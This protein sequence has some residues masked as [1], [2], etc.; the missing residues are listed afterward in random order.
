M[1]KRIHVNI[2]AGILG[3]LYLVYFFTV[4]RNPLVLAA[5]DRPAGL[6]EIA[7][8]R[9][10]ALAWRLRW[11][12]RLPGVLARAEVPPL[13]FAQATGFAD[14]SADERARHLAARL[15]LT[16]TGEGLSLSHGIRL[17]RAETP[18]RLPLN[19]PRLRLLMV[20]STVPRDE[21]LAALY[22][23]ADGRGIPALVISLDDGQRQALRDPAIDP[24]TMVAVPTGAELTSLLL[25]PQ[26]LDVF[27]RS[28]ASQ[29]SVT[30]ISLYQR[31]G[32]VH[33]S[34]GFF[35]R[36]RELS[37]ILNRDLANYFLIGSRQIGKS[38][39]MKEI[40][41]RGERRPD[42]DCR[43][44]TLTGPDPRGP[45]ARALGMDPA[46]PLDSV[47]D[48]LP[49]DG[50]RRRLILIDEADQF[51]AADAGH[52]YPVLSAFRRLSEEG[53][54]FFILAGFWELHRVIAYDYQSP[55]RN[56][57][58]PLLLGGLDRQAC[59]DLATRPMASLALS[60]ASP[61][62]PALI[63]ERTGGRANLIAIVC[64]EILAELPPGERIIT[65]QPVIDA[66]NGGAVR[67][68]LGGWGQLSGN[69][70][71]RDNRLD[72][73]I[74]YSTVAEESFTLS[75][76]QH[77]LHAL[78]VSQGAEAIRQALNRLELAY[79]IV[80][81]ADGLY[82]YRVPVFTA[83]LRSLDLP[84]ALSEEVGASASS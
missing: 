32:G 43:Y 79:I 51:V 59:L 45:L 33:D 50:D 38:S 72:R 31:G 3:L 46:A 74:V 77:R 70:A 42:I 78:G 57:G 21:I 67:D 73:L 63:A 7:P 64:A 24:D 53:R 52:G 82:R 16:L 44:L 48:A 84:L 28:V 15:E 60:Y 5:T 40:Q 83:M 2:G 54:A 18:D 8:E 55:L 14:R 27:A 41:R 81:G 65:E 49:A 61:D 1:I 62:L 9:L 47:L 23:D 20:P 36:D 34:A 71:E 6:L 13:R 37:H 17:Y 11:S 56:F 26:P 30:R 25:G 10:T 4:I 80:Q 68:V 12:L 22:Q 69:D 39:L 75:A 58:E 76:L 19:M 29:V 66:L 35:G